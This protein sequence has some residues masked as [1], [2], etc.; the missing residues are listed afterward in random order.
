[1]GSICPKLFTIM[2]VAPGGGTSG[3]ERWGGREGA[4]G[5]GH[6]GGGLGGAEGGVRC[7][8]GGVWGWRGDDGGGAGR[9]GRGR[10]GDRGGRL[11]PDRVVQRGQHA[12]AADPVPGRGRRDGGGPAVGAVRRGPVRGRVHG[13][14]RGD[15]LA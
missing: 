8:G 9:G 1:M 6:G 12:G 5:A 2:K 13:G 11:S 14:Q 7:G 10:G 15:V 3:G 4:A